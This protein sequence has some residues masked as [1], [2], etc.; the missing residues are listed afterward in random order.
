M[1]WF[2]Q[3]LMIST[4]LALDSFNVFGLRQD[5]NGQYA[6]VIPRWIDAVMRGED[7]LSMVMAQQL[8]IFVT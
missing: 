8:E 3:K 4:L 6:A 1:Q 2:F 5:P 7:L